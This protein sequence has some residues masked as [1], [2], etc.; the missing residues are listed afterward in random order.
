M[1]KKYAVLLL[2]VFTVTIFSVL[3]NAEYKTYDGEKIIKK[4]IYPYKFIF[5]GDNRPGYGKEQPEV[6]INMIKMINEEDPLFVIGGG[7]FV[8]EGTPGNFEEFL[9]A[10]SN[11]KAPLF[12]VC[13]NHDNSRYYE[14]YLGEK[15]YSFTYKNSIF[16]VLNDSRGIL[17]KT[18][19]RFLKTQLKRNFK[20]KF[21]FMHIPPFDPRPEEN[22]CMGDSEEF[23]K[24]IKEN[25]VDFVF[26]SH[27]HSYYK[28][29]IGN[30]TFVISGG[31]GA[32]L[33]NNGFYHYIVV[34]V[35]DNISFSV[36][37]YGEICKVAIS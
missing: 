9:K 15:V 11:L 10:V 37:R 12:Y 22:H 6:F 28:E 29:K 4:D 13:G 25:N 14:K 35:G 16:I 24:I 21:V 5:F 34:N 1:N 19:L 2:I 27:I 36:V 7:D 8:V 33:V 31:A 32:P 20:H 17:D 3:N 23:M 30:T 18:Q 26:C